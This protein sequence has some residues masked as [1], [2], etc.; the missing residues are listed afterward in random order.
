MD[1]GKWYPCFNI[2]DCCYM[3]IVCLL[4]IRDFKQIIHICIYIWIEF[5]YDVLV[6]LV[7]R[8]AVWFSLNNDMLRTTQC[9]LSL[10]LCP[11][12]LASK[13]FP[14]TMKLTKRCKCKCHRGAKHQIHQ[15]WSLRIKCCMRFLWLFYIKFYIKISRWWWIASLVETFSVCIWIFYI[16]FLFS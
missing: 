8:V 9:F 2:P 15:N 10:S 12:Y 11:F 3:C 4:F 16:L 6:T 7:V 13:T 14:S 5:L 1:A